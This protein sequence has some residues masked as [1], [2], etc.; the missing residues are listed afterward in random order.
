MELSLE[1]KPFSFE[2]V[3]PLNTS[4]GIINKKEGW[5]LNIQD[6][7]GK[8]G[9]GE[10]AP[11]NQHEMSECENLLNNLEKKLSKRQLEVKL[12]KSSG[13]FAF[14][15]GAALAEIESLIDLDI[16][17]NSST[18]LESAFLLPTD[19]SLISVLES[20]LNEQSTKDEN[21][22]FKWKVACLPNEIEKKLLDK[23][24]NRLPSKARLRI[25]P[26]AGWDRKTAKDWVD[27]LVNESKLEWIEQPLSSSDLEGMTMLSK[28]IPI[29][30]DESLIDYPVLRQ[31]WKSWQIRK[32]LLEGDPRQ[33]LKELNDKVGYRVISSSFET[34]IG[35]RWTQY[36]ATLQQQ[37]PTPT[38]PGLGPGWCPNTPLFSD[39]PISVWNAA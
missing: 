12:L 2:L 7:T 13:A 30:L 28:H 26:N 3:K 15:I 4:K 18:W 1:I 5:L 27:Y 34:G 35:R 8:N 32:P 20:K 29:A 6:E 33:L 25:D 38:A 19:D 17:N 9:W 14:G 31:T 23:I 36:L 24:L 37:G 21:I 39:H 10:I 11:L 22:T 16:N